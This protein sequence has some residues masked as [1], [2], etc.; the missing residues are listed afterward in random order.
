MRFDKLKWNYII[1]YSQ[2]L[3]KVSISSVSYF[4]TG[5]PFQSIFSTWLSFIQFHLKK[6]EKLTESLGVYIF[7]LIKNE[8]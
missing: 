5:M 1:I 3:F 6:N 7:F 8:K 4:N 2:K